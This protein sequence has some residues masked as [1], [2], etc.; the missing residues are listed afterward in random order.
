MKKIILL[1][2]TF[3]VINFT[4][5][6]QEVMSAKFKTLDSCLVAIKRNTNQELK[7]ITNN[8]NEV[9]GLLA[10]NKAF[11][12]KKKVSG[13]DGVYFDGWFMLK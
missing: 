6:A 7:I 12:C 5:H 2:A 11:G 3:L 10:N 13:T 4:A 1:L 9:S 8:S